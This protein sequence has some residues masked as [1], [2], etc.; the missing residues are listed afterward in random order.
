[1]SAPTKEELHDRHLVLVTIDEQAR[2]ISIRILGAY[3]ESIGVRTTLLLI[4]RDL[5]TYGNPIVFS[6]GEIRQLAAFLEREGVTHLGFY[7]MTASL[8]PYRL[9]VQALRSAGYKGVIMAGGV[10]VWLRPEESL[11]EGADYAVQGP[12]EVPL[13]M[14]LRHEDPATIP[15]LVWRRGTSVKINPTSKAQELPLDSL[16]FPLF[17]FDRDRVLVGGRLQRFT[18]DVHR[19]YANWDGRYYDLVTSRGC[20]YKCAYCCNVY[21]SPIRRAGVDR[22]IRE[23]KHLKESE[24]RIRGINIQDDS[25]FAGSDDWVREFC[26]RMKAEIGLTFI[27]RMIPHAVT[28]ERLAVMKAAGLSYVTMGLEG[29]DRINRTLFNRKEDA[30]SFLKAAHAV[31]DA[32]LLLSIDYI[33]N[34]PYETE[35]DLRE[36]ATTLNALPRPHWWIL[37][38]SLT[39]FPGTALHTRCVKDQMLGRF[40]TDAYDAMLKPSRPDG[41]STPLFW[42]QLITTVLPRVK[43]ALGE[44]LIALGPRHPKAAQT[45]DA[46]ARWIVKTQ[47]AT[48]WTREHLPW[49]YALA[50]RMLRP[51]AERKENFQ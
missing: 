3:A 37:P 10:H 47:R 49:A 7:L 23:L 20:V 11:V 31:L 46:L 43:P 40:A 22:I 50:G 4:L 5:A 28:P 9:L 51:F 45:V 19:R 12:G 39:P 33:I 26:A 29:S 6:D 1:M 42:L 17:R 14:I 44:R 32:G 34:N 38:L 35:D 16:P 30:A 15:G 25:F 13:A 8:K 48:R 27:A 36:V 21:G 41:Y 24:P 18:W 2:P